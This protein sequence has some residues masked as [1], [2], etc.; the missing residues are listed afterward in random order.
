MM[1]GLVILKYIECLSDEKLISRCT[2]DQYYQAFIG[3]TSFVN[4]KPCDRT[5]L[6][7]FRKRIGKEGAE[8]ILQNSIVINGK[9]AAEEVKK[10]LI[11]DSTVQEN[12]TAFPTDTKLT[13]DV[14][15]QC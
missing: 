15:H 12:F 8:I 1:V 7:V 10:E 2:Q 6:S 9:S 13:L 3:R 4:S 14:I 11:T 5:L